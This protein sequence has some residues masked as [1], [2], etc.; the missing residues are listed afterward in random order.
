MFSQ[1]YLIDSQLCIAV[2]W[3][4]YTVVLHRRTDL[5]AARAF[6]LLLVPLGLLL[7]LLRLPLLPPQAL[8]AAVSDGLPVDTAFRT[9][10][11]ITVFQVMVALYVTGAAIGL[12]STVWDIFRTWV[13]TK[14]VKPQIAG[15]ERLVFSSDVAGAYSVFGTIFVNDKYE[16]SPALEHILAHERSHI[17]RR[18]SLDLIW[19]RFWRCLLW[20]NPTVWHC[21]KLLREVHEFQ[22]DRD[23]L[24]QGNPVAPYVELL[25]GAEAGIYPGN[26]H[27]FSY[28]LTKKRLRMIERATRKS[29]VGGYLRLAA[30]FPLAGVLAG[31]FSLTSRAADPNEPGYPEA[32]TIQDGE[33]RIPRENL[34]GTAGI[35]DS[36]TVRRIT[37]RVSPAESKKGITAA[38]KALREYPDLFYLDQQGHVAN[39]IPVSVSIIKEQ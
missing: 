4:F 20:F 5:R 2:F 18:H 37:V 14:R 12:L 15:R 17:A 33:I 39:R 38:A 34:V 27:A 6:L 24:L 10:S 26:A 28:S 7:P 22:A 31:A 29:G 32:F 21:L 35:Y 1:G 19:M 11:G 23:V 25:V 3:L 9:K 16:G 8:P 36:A 30:L 13:R